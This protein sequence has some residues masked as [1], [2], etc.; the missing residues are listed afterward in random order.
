MSDSASAKVL[1]VLREGGVQYLA[2]RF[3]SGTRYLIDR[4]CKVMEEAAL[5]CQTIIEF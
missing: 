3:T 5:L 1:E 4:D 2:L